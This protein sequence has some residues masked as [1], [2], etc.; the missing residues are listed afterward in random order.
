MRP[1]Q[2]FRIGSLLTMF[3][4]VVDCLD[5]DVTSFM[6]AKVFENEQGDHVA[7]LPFERQMNQQNISETKEYSC[8]T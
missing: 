3:T 4:Q 8:A 2:L 5:L 7:K 6:L 1:P